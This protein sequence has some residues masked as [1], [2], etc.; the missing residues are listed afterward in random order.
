MKLGPFI[1]FMNLVAVLFGLYAAKFCNI[2][3][4]LC[5]GRCA[6][7]ATIIIQFAFYY[8]LPDF[9]V[10]VSAILIVLGALIAGWDSL[11]ANAVGYGY[12]WLNNTTQAFQNVFTQKYNA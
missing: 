10:S 8:K 3:L 9:R 7:I 2:P 6:I 11:N 4:L 1:A 5:Q 12:V